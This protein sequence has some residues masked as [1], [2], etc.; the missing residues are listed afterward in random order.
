MLKLPKGFVNRLTGSFL[1][2][3][4]EP[5]KEDRQ[6]VDCGLNIKNFTKKVH[7]PDYVRFVAQ[8]SAA[9]NIYDEF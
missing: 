8:D 3:F 6:V 9:N 2:A 7:I 4:D 5:G 1:I